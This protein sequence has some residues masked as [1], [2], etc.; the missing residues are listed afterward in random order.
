MATDAYPPRAHDL[1]R[2]CYAEMGVFHV[3]QRECLAT[4]PLHKGRFPRGQR[5]RGVELTHPSEGTCLNPI[6]R[7]ARLE[8]DPN[9]AS[10]CGQCRK[11]SS[12]KPVKIRTSRR[13]CTCCSNAVTLR[14]CAGPA[15]D[16]RSR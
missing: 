5:R 13:L 12:S 4:S 8:Q 15:E 9:K 1:R 7:S 14:A 2:G 11:Q 10:A 6:E 3:R 16:L